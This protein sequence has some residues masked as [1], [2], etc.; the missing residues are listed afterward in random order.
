MEIDLDRYLD[1]YSET[2]GILP[3]KLE[4]YGEKYREQGHLTQDQLY[5]IAY[6]SSTRS[7]YHVQNNPEDRCR[8]VTSNVLKVD[9]DFSRIALISSLRGFKAPTA[10]CVLTALD[11]E[12]HAVVDTRVWASL[13]RLDRVEGRKESFGPSDYVRMIEEIRDMASGT[14]RSA[15][16]VGYALFAHDYDVREGTLH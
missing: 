10:S 9:G 12:R 15:A 14:G 1:L 13:E 5:E 11:P 16:E 4:S 7:A 2:Q 8:E 3:G 6:E